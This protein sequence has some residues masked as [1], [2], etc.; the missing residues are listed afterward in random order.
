MMVVVLILILSFIGAKGQMVEELEIP[1]GVGFDITKA[2]SIT[3]NKVPIIVYSFEEGGRVSSNV[4]MGTGL[5]IGETRETRQLKSSRK[6]LLGLT[7]II[8]YSEESARD[9]LRNNIDVLVNNPEINDRALCVICKGKAEDMLKYKVKG[10]PS[11]ADYIYGMVKNSNQFNFMSMQYT[12]MDMVVRVDAEGRNVIL[13]YIEITE[14]GIEITGT[15]IFRGDRMVGKAD[16]R[17]SRVINLLKED[18]VKGIITIQKNSKE[19]IDCY[20]QSKRKV[21]CERKD[22]NYKFTINLNLKGKVVNNSLYNKL[23]SDVKTLKALEEDMK[24]TAE[25]MCEEYINKIKCEYKA[26]VLDL[27]RMAVAKYGRG[28]GTDWNSVIC[29]SIIEVKVNF[30]VDTEGRGDY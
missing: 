9:G 13:P 4:L 10:V 25:K 24:K 30:K 11:S 1:I 26:D 23:N 15:A 17:E 6:F 20:V 14:D 18:K 22:G 21:K 28:T 8:V 3:Y 2:S 29:N 7:R 12:I 19:Y 16:I 5:S 27:G